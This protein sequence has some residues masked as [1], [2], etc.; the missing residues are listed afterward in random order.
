MMSK[1]NHIKD[2]KS[3]K[4]YKY[5][6]KIDSNYAESIVSF[7]SVTEPVLDSIKDHFPFY[8]RHDARHGYEVAKRMAEILK[9]DC[10]KQ[11]SEN[12]LLPIEVFLLIASAYAHD[13]GMTIYEEQEEKNK[14][15]AELKIDKTLSNWEKNESLQN[16]LRK[17]SC[18]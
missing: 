12:A 8:T 15:L 10:L 11:N 2:L 3:L 14:I 7:V 13:I 17:K 16:Y 6:K 5:L 18:R 1:F 9:E 4:L